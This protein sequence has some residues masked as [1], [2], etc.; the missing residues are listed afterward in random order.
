MSPSRNIQVCTTPIRQSPTFS[1]LERCT[2]CILNAIAL[3]MHKEYGPEN[4]A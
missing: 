2:V 1:L 3:Y 4:L